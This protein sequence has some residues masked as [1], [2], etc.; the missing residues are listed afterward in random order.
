M[1]IMNSATDNSLY[2]MK[3][4]EDYEWLTIAV[5]RFLHNHGNIATE[6]SLKSGLCP[7]IEY[8]VQQIIHCI[9]YIVQ[10]EK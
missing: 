10:N 5:R 1:Y 3:S 7:R 2:R 8:K 4:T 9:L 6:W